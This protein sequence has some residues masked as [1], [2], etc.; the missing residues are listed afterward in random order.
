M[1]LIPQFGQPPLMAKRRTAMAADDGKVRGCKGEE[2]ER[3][4]LR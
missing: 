2:R 1:R 4:T 3:E